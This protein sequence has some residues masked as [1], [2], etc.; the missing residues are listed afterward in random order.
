MISGV[1]PILLSPFLENG[2]FDRDGLKKLSEY[3]IH[4]H[5]DGLVCF[6]EVSEPNS[7]T[8]DEREYI[9]KETKRMAGKLPIIAGIS[10]DRVSDTL[11]MVDSY[12]DEGVSAFLLAP[13]KNPGMPQDQIYNFYRDVDRHLDLSVIIL[14]QPAR[15]R[16]VMSPELIVKI[17]RNTENVR[18]LK[19]EDQ[20]TPMKMDR[21]NQLKEKN[22][23]ILGASHGRNFYWELERGA[24]GILTSTPL[25]EILVSIWRSYTSGNNEAARE[26]F[27]RSLPLAY[28]Y[29]DAP[30]AVK[31]EVLRYTGRINSAKMRQMGLVLSDSAIEDLWKL[32]DW[33]KKSLDE[34]RVNR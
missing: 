23:K 16:P 7:L 25:P 19:V 17:V 20:P 30:V 12:R 28:Y 15:V 11:A 33:T 21:I 13:P 14:D 24:S 4:E 10:S 5:V 6:G 3:Y 2:D 18:Y 29:S 34:V 22:L 9:L 32:V 8:V 1:I 26:I 27:Y 31:K